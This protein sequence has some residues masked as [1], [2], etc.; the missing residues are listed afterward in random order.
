MNTRQF[1]APPTPRARFA[2]ALAALCL[3]AAPS[4]RFV[5]T[6]LDP[7]VYRVSANAPGYVEEF[8]P[9]ADPSEPRNLYRPGDSVTLRLTKGGVITGKVTDAAGEPVVGARVA[10]VRLRDG[11]GR[12]VRE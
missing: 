8:D 5:L 12:I 9:T 10:T 3:A 6:N 11:A 4:G 2:L 7:G 1:P